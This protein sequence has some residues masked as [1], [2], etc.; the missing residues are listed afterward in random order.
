MVVNYVSV[1]YC[2]YFIFF[3]T[4][5]CTKLTLSPATEVTVC[6]CSITLLHVDY[7]VVTMVGVAF[8]CVWLT[9][10]FRFW[11]LD[12]WLLTVVSFES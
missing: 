12:K 4:F 9:D 11:S 5:D 10:M 6:T 2:L 3:P 8:W 1:D 7:L